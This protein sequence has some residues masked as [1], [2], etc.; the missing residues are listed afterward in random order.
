MQLPACG[1]CATFWFGDRVCWTRRPV[2]DS[3]HSARARCAGWSSL[4]PCAPAASC[5]RSHGCKV[6][7]VPRQ[8]AVPASP[9]VW[10]PWAL[11]SFPPLSLALAMPPQNFSGQCC[12]APRPR[13]P[14]SMPACCPVRR[15][16]VADPAVCCIWLAAVSAHAALLAG[17]PCCCHHL[18]LLPA[19]FPFAARRPSRRRRFSLLHF[20]SSLHPAPPPPNRCHQQF[21]SHLHF[22]ITDYSSPS[23]QRSLQHPSYQRACSSPSPI[24]IAAIP[25]IAALARVWRAPQLLSGAHVLEARDATAFAT[26]IHQTLTTSVLLATSSPRACLSSSRRPRVHPAILQ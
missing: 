19:G 3:K 22:R 25:S 7:R 5:H 16:L 15:R 23:H 21:H 12:P 1:R 26:Q 2:K 6:T 17:S 13:S 11:P 10:P 9:L 8:P 18:C 14:S 20:C 24:V 4:C